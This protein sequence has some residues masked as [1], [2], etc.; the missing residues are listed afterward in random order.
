[1]SKCVC[2]D[3]GGSTYSGVPG[4]IG[5]DPCTC[6]R[7]DACQRISSDDDARHILE[8]VNKLVDSNALRVLE[9]NKN[10]VPDAFSREEMLVIMEVANDILSGDPTMND[11]WR[12]YA[13]NRLDL[14]ED[15]LN[16]IADKL[17]EYMGRVKDA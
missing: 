11:I 8:A 14:S 13:G 17:D 5:T 6:E 7:C 4:I 10:L 16:R 2:E 15:E 1:M 12:D 9:A 3:A